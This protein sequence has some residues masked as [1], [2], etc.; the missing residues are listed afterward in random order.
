MLYFSD[1]Q[2][3]DWEPEAFKGNNDLYW[4]DVRKN[5][6]QLQ[7]KNMLLYLATH[8]S[9]KCHLEFDHNN[10]TSVTQSTFLNFTTFYLL[11]LADNKISEIHENSL[12]HLVLH[13]LILK[14]NRIEQFPPR[15][16]AGQT[17]LVDLYMGHNPI[18]YLAENFFDGLS[19]L[20]LLNLSGLTIWNISSRMFGDKDLN[21]DHMWE[22][23]KKCLIFTCTTI[24][25]LTAYF[26]RCTTVG[27]HLTSK[28]VTHD[29]MASPARRTYWTTRLCGYSAGPLPSLQSPSTSSSYLPDATSGKDPANCTR[30]SPCV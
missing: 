17:K 13:G 9:S 11:S 24:A 7:K 8:C 4:V 29:T 27:M 28:T 18:Q 12:S 1:N 23:S 3:V 14:G 21:I 30:F 5:Q 15:L 19:H 20:K 10:I 16:L 6:L 26:Q 22:T 25:F 2:L